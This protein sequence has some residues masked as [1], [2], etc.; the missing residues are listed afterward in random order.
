MCHASDVRNDDL[1]SRVRSVALATA[2]VAVLCLGLPLAVTARVLVVNDEG[3]EVERIA[4]TTAAQLSIDPPTADDLPELPQQE[5]QVD[6]AFYSPQGQRVVGTG[7]DVSDQVVDRAAAGSV[8]AQGGGW[9]LALPGGTG[10]SAAAPVTDGSSVVGVVRAASDASALWVR[11]L[12]AWAALGTACLI[13]VAISLVLARHSAARLGGHVA[14]LRMAALAIGDG[15]LSRASP[16]SGIRELDE[17][18]HALSATALRLSDQL[19]RERA[20]GAATSH[21]LRTPVMRLQLLL[22]SARQ[23]PDSTEQPDPADLLDQACQEAQNLRTQLEELL[24]LNRA[25]PA[26]DNTGEALDLRSMLDQVHQRYDVLAAEQQRRLVVGLDSGLP[27]VTG[28]ASAIAHAVDVLVDNALKH[29]QG[30]VRIWARETV[31]TVAIDI[32]DE[33]AGFNAADHKGPD[34]ATPQSLGL[35]LATALIE[36]QSGRLI[37]PGP[38]K[39]PRVSIMMSPSPDPE[40]FS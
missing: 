20:L 32:S 12:L 28:S 39:A 3:T 40:D 22:D 13:A 16:S 23:S 15:D 35:S 2:V 18:G 36:A 25:G 17:V 37:L 29:G 14:R 7:P 11:T 19:Q 1:A 4:V 8:G 33:G 27:P 24:Q 9:T 6:L 30:T 10:V 38:G 31:G 34:Q 5:G 21:Q 26:A